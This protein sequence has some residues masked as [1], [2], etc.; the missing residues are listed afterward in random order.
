MFDIF[1]TRKTEENVNKLNLQYIDY[2][3]IEKNEK[4]FFDISKI[5]SLAEDILENGLEKPVLVVKT[6]R[7]FRIVDGERRFTAMKYNIDHSKTQNIYIPCIIREIEDED[8]IEKRLILANLM[9]REITPGEKLKAIERLEELYQKE[10]VENKLPKRIRTLIAEA[11]GLKETQVGTYQTINKNAIEDVKEKLSDGEITVEVAHELSKLAPEAQ[12]EI[13]SQN[14]TISKETIQSYSKESNEDDEVEN[15]HLESEKKLEFIN[16]VFN[17]QY[18]NL[19]LILKK[20]KCAEE[21]KQLKK[22]QLE[23]HALLK[24]TKEMIE[25]Q[26]E[27]NSH[28]CN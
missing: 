23:M 22:L 5:E 25:K 16:G 14:E 4:N 13:L 7:G 6:N 24:N 10:K 20:Y 11:T 1:G 27:E 28:E 8:T 18:Q 15:E 21:F 9:N 17:A 19:A 3:D 2:R 26:L 12:T